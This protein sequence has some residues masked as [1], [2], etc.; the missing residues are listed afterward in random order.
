LE[1]DELLLFVL[2]S[3]LDIEEKDDDEL[4]KHGLLDE[5]LE[6]LDDEEGSDGEDEDELRD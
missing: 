3:E 5:L 6:L 2:E 4:E 1:D